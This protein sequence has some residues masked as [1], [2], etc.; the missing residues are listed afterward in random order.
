MCENNRHRDPRWQRSSRHLA[1]KP[2]APANANIYIDALGF[3]AKVSSTLTKPRTLG[4]VGIPC[5]EGRKILNSRDSLAIHLFYAF[6][7]S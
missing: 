3:T 5:A 7:I 2:V 1:C 6:T 4:E